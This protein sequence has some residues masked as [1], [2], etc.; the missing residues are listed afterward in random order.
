M[1]EGSIYTLPL[2]RQALQLELCSNFWN[3][4]KMKP[5][6]S[7]LYFFLNFSTYRKHGRTRHVNAHFL[8]AIASTKQFRVHFIK[9]T[10]RETVLTPRSVIL[11]HAP[12][13][14]TV[15]V[16]VK[17]QP[18]K[19]KLKSTAIPTLRSKSSAHC[20]HAY[21]IAILSFIR[22]N[23]KQQS[24]ISVSN[25]A[26]YS[27]TVNAVVLKKY[28]AILIIKFCTPLIIP[29]AFPGTVNSSWR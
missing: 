19:V 11:S 24:M 3:G 8:I 4:F 17:V 22:K 25:S 12:F 14:T 18:W 10:A 2:P 20:A 29:L 27:I 1:T 7:G 5:C 28:V 13:P 15:T 21:F 26:S 16:L 9:Y 6:S 23:H